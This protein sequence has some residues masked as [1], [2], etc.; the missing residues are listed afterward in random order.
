MFMANPFTTTLRVWHAIF[1]REAL[2]RLFGM[3]A[4]WM[5]LIVEPA[6]HI[7]FISFVWT[8]L[9][10]R[11]MGG[12]DVMLW[13]IVGMLAFFLFRRTAIQAMHAIDC[14]RAFF[15]FRQVRP[16]DA[17][18]V[19]AGVEAFVMSII[20]L[21]IFT[22]TV[23][24][25]RNPLPHDP[26]LVIAAVAGLWLFGLGYGLVASV[27]MRL[28][29]ETTHILQ[30]LMMP[31]YLLSGVIWPIVSIPPLYRDWLMVN[32]LVHGLEAART[33]FF[34]TY[35]TVPDVSLSYLYLWALCSVCL[36][37]ALYRVYETRLVMQ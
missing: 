20:S 10:R 4:A 8:V 16:F 27:L 23:F 24:T 29:P 37:L 12:V 2:D 6:M 13:I 9:R 30:I 17:A 26:L 36:G 25:G 1:L 19:R 5:W 15:A 21:F 28:I 32:P 3:R 35:H 11:S 34:A 22:A 18:F 33:G 14:N 7:G 31:L